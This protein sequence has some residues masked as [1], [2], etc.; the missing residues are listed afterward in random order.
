M[1]SETD[2]AWFAP[3]KIGYGAGLPIVWQ[4]WA[5]LAVEVGGTVALMMTLTGAR[6]GIGIAAATGFNVLFMPLIAKKTRGGWK[7]RNGPARASTSLERTD[8]YDLY[9]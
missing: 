3:K 6:P 1:M 8:L 2:G 4:G 5:L 9:G 7:W